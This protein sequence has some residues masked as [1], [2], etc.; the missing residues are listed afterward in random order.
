MQKNPENG[1]CVFLWN[2]VSLF[3]LGGVFAEHHL[4]KEAVLRFW[5]ALRDQ[6][7]W[8]PFFFV[9]KV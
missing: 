5:H 1:M 9:K 7:L 8:R 6:V 2:K 4:V 3:F